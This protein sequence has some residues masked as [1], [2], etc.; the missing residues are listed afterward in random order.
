MIFWIKKY[1][2]VG[3]TWSSLF[4]SNQQAGTVRLSNSTMETYTQATTGN[5][6]FGWGGLIA[7]GGNPFAVNPIDIL[8]VSDS[9]AQLIAINTDTKNRLV[10]T[11]KRK[12]YF[13]V[14]S[15]W[16]SLFVSNQQAGTVRLSN[17]TMETY[18]QATTGNIA[19][20]TG[21][22]LNCFSCH[23]AGFVPQN[24]SENFQILQANSFL[25]HVFG[26][27]IAQ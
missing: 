5:I 15:T 26:R 14:G 18:T 11:D 10:S 3:S 27:N 21:A 1:F 20:P 12:K 17:S 2:Q 24:Q 23:D 7:S 4:V 19:L 8:D 6:A 9:N 22:G 25:S 13:Q 16:S